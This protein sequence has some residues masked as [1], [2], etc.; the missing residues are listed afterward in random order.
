MAK[1]VITLTVNGDEHE[2]AVAPYQTLLEVLRD[3]I[4]NPS[5][6]HHFGQRAKAVLDQAR[7]EV[8]ALVE[9]DPADIV[10]TGG[11][12]ESDNLAIRGA[13]EA[14][15][16]SGRRHI[17]ATARNACMTFLKTSLQPTC[18][19]QHQKKNQKNS[20][21]TKQLPISA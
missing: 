19:M 18:A 10:F 21:Y 11:G 17:I 3:E 12:T 13:A 2:L 20:S 5:S 14:G 4:G 15:W 7:A 16:A 9:S 8:A 1:Q 6:V